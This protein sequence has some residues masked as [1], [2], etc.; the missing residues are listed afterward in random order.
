[1]R[2][3]ARSGIYVPAIK[4]AVSAGV[5]ITA[6]WLIEN[7]GLTR[8]Q[9]DNVLTYARHIGVVRRIERG[10]HMPAATEA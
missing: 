10:H 9:A 6:K 8:R 4:K 2:R 1:M 5:D 3:N 7:C